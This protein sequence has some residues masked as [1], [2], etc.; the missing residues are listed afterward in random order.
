MLFK[1][2]LKNNVTLLISVTVQRVAKSDALSIIWGNP[3]RN[4][5]KFDSDLQL[6]FLVSNSLYLSQDL[7]PI[8]NPRKVE[9]HGNVIIASQRIIRFRCRFKDTTA[10]AFADILD[11]PGFRLV[12]DFDF[13]GNKA[14][15]PFM[16]S[17]FLLHHRCGVF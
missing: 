5:C 10:A 15:D 6:F 14:A 12:I 7:L 11:D 2:E 3:P 13:S 8:D 9:A 1:G 17:G 16:G 4:I